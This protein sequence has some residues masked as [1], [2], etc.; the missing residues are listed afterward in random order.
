MLYLAIRI[1]AFDTLIM[2]YKQEF[3]HYINQFYTKLTIIASKVLI[4]VI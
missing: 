3:D 1:V 4:L 2:R